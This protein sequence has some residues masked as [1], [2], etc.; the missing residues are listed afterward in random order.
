MGKR[1]IALFGL[2]PRRTS[3]LIA[4]ITG[5]LITGLTI[6]TL[7]LTSRNVRDMLVHLDEIRSQREAAIRERNEAWASLDTM[8]ATIDEGQ[9][10]IDYQKAQVGDLTYQLTT[11]ES[12][13]SSV[14]LDLADLNQQAHDL[15]SERD[16]LNT[17]LQNLT[18]LKETQAAELEAKIS[19]LNSQIGGLNSQIS[20]REKR[21]AEL[22]SVVQQWSGGKV[23]VR[24]GQQ[25][26]AF[27][28]STKL[29]ENS[30]DTQLGTQLAAIRYNYHD[31]NTNEA[32]LRDNEMIIPQDAFNQAIQSIHAMPSDNAIVIAYTSANVLE[33]EP[34]TLRIDVTSDFKVYS[35]GSSIFS[36]TYDKPSEGSDPERAVVAS[37]FEAAKQYMV[38]DRN[39]IPT[40]S[41]EL[42]Q[43]TY[44]EMVALADKLKHVG[45]PAQIGMVALTDIYRTDFLV[46]GE[47]FKVD[48]VTAPGG[49]EPE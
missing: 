36:K 29:D 20:E 11:T 1:R 34:V 13:L 39:I 25:L 47:Q 3:V 14:Q 2:R 22:N 27:K 40:G 5:M 15:T 41:G 35:S 45:F 23:K 18:K 9:K 19:D 48:I 30:L 4:I 24:E 26:A 37:F 28:I 38:T 21:V 16:N 17:E 32:V 33:N 46:Y 31:P 8:K 49:P 7:A 44:D 43:A 6:L 12:D 42:I 10:T